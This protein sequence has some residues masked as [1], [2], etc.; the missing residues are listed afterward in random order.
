MEEDSKNSSFQI[1]C[2]F[3]DV[4]VL[5]EELKNMKM[6][7][8]AMNLRLNIKDKQIRKLEKYITLIHRN[9]LSQQCL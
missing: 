5:K 9:I 6:K 4:Q 1:D 2:F 3:V 8:K 7:E